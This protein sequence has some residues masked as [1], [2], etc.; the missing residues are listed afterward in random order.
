MS[1][2]ILTTDERG[3]RAGPESTTSTAPTHL[4]HL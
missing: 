4:H 1:N 3:Q 2:G